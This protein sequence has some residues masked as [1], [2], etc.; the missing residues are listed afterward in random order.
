MR[1]LTSLSANFHPQCQRV[2]EMTDARRAL[3]GLRRVS[4]GLTVQEPRSK[5]MA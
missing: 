3:N 4:V 5:S 1:M 2:V